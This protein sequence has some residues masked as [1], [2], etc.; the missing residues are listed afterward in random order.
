MSEI[1]PSD[2]EARQKTHPLT[3]YF[4]GLFGLYKGLPGPIYTLFIATVVNGA[5]IFVFP[6]L[7]LLL[8]KRLGWS[9]SE[10]GNFIFLASFVYIPGGLVGGKFADRF[11]RKKVMVISQAAA[12]LVFGVC[13]FLGDSPLLPWLILVHLFFD[14][15]TD[16]ARSAMQIDLVPAE[17]RQAAF[18]FIYLGHNLGFAF[19]PLIAGYLFYA[20]PSWLFFGNAIAI[21]LALGL[22][23]LF[24]PETIPTAEEMEAS[25]EKN[26]DEAGH[27]GGLFAA[28][29]S[30]PY[31]LV[32][33]LLTTVYGFV[34]AQHRFALPLQ[35]DAWFGEGGAKLY[36]TLMTLNAVMVIVFATP[37][38]H[39]TRRWRPIV[40]V[41]AAGFLFSAGFWM[42]GLA[43]TPLLLYVSTAI[44][45]LGEIVNATN[46]ETYV[47]SHTPITHRGRFRTVIQ[48]IGGAGFALSPAIMGDLIETRGLAPVWPLIGI[49]GAA[50]AAGLVVL[51]LVEE[52]K[53]RAR[54]LERAS[55]EVH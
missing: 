49:A 19:G 2:G 13:G 46:D 21:A 11:G 4:R 53:R 14:G 28:L 25:F 18:S 30:R 6:F 22:V 48:F 15:I 50:A 31:L 35:T 52:R 55:V 16:P 33:L 8:T 3:D 40:N 7:T 32:Y 41:A 47:A 29:F 43:K 36:G 1:E 26:S 54:A 5:G 44:W 39:L 34:Y 17:K 45:T 51:G 12:G 37:V 38:V 9:A 20:A 23:L 27:R 10:A 24:V 42:I